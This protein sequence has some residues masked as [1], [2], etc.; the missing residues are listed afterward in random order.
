MSDDETLR[1]EKIAVIVEFGFPWH[2]ESE[3]A[4]VLMVDSLS[5]ASV[6]GL[7]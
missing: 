1:V 3:V 2:R 6:R 4:L 7:R 5:E